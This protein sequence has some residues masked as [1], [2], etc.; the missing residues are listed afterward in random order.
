MDEYENYYASMLETLSMNEMRDED[1]ISIYNRI[2][3]TPVCRR[4]RPKYNPINPD[5]QAQLLDYYK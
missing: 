4:R 5:H 2:H 1:R 3:L